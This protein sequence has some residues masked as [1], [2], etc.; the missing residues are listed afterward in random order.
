MNS[1]I[2]FGPEIWTLQNQGGVSRYNFELCT[3]ISSIYDYSRILL[4]Y[5]SSNHY[6]D[7]LANLGNTQVASWRSFLNISP[8]NRIRYSSSIYHATYYNYANILYWKLRGAKIVVTVHDMIPEIF[9]EPKPRISRLNHKRKSIELADLILCNSRSTQR[10]LVEIYGI[11][12]GITRVTH[13]GISDLFAQPTSSLSYVSRQQTLLYVGQRRGYKNFDDFLIGFSKSEFLRENYNL[14]CFGGGNFSEQESDL[15]TE[16]GLSGNV[17]TASGNDEALIDMYRKV[18][19]LVYPSIYEGFG[20][21]I[22]EAFS[23]GCPVFL[24]KNSSMLEICGKAGLALN[25][26]SPETIMQSLVTGLRN[27]DSMI[28]Q[29]SLGLE[30]A[31]KFSWDKMARETLQAYKEMV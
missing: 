21:P 23:Q 22:I 6:F 15:I 17:F 9:P 3:R 4:P 8:E 14:V 11:N 2:Y 19:A 24:S 18:A 27:R 16:L 1:T 29:Q 30:Q 5:F 12:E 31:R 25:L 10:D 13:L 20:L 26:E 28:A 7:S